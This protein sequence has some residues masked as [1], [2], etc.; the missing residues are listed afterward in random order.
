MET[1]AKRIVA[2]IVLAGIGV[3]TVGGL[4]FFLQPPD[5]RTIYSTPVFLPI[6][7]ISLEMVNGK[8]HIWPR[9]K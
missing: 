7:V 5:Y 9:L 3:A 8:V 2:I 4:W 1:K 6:Q